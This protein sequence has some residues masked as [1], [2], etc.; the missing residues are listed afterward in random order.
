MY[1]Q[2]ENQL[3]SQHSHDFNYFSHLSYN[4]NIY[5]YKIIAGANCPHSIKIT[6]SWN[7]I[8]NDKIEKPSLIEK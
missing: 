8:P 1:P 2:Y 3:I 7:T 4:A 6:E 5:L